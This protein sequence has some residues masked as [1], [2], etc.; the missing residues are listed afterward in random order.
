MRFRILLLLPLCM[1]CSRPET[2]P[3]SRVSS[4]P[5]SELQALQAQGITISA[6]VSVSVS[7]DKKFPLVLDPATNN[8]KGDVSVPTG[9]K[10][11]LTVTYTADDPTAGQTLQIA[12]YIRRNLI[13]TESTT[14]VSYEG[15]QQNWETTFDL[16]P[17]QVNDLNSDG[18]AY[19]NFIEIGYGSNPLA[20]TSLPLGAGINATHPDPLFG[21]TDVSLPLP[22][23]DLTSALKGDQEIKI[24]AVT[25]FHIQKIDIV[26]PT[27]GIDI[28]STN[29]EIRQ[30]KSL[31]LR[32]HTARFG[33]S[34]RMDIVIRTTDEF[35]IIRD[36]PL[37]FAIFNSTDALPPLRLQ[38]GL[39]EGQVV[40]DTTNFVWEI[41]DPSG[42]DP[43]SIDFH[44]T[45]PEVRVDE[46]IR[47]MDEDTTTTRFRG[48]A[49]LSTIRYPNGTYTATFA[50]R[51]SV[52][53]AYAET[54]HFQVLNTTTVGFCGNQI[55]E[56]GEECDDGNTLN[57]DSCTN[58]CRIG[59]CG[60]GIL[61]AGE[62]CDDGNT[63]DNDACTN[64][65]QPA[66]CGDGT[67]A[68]TEEC[69]DGNLISNDGC[70]STCRLEPAI[71][72]IAT[73][74]DG[75][76][77]H[78]IAN[79]QATAINRSGISLSRFG[80][81]LP[82]G[83]V[84]T[85]ASTQNFQSV[86]DTRQMPEDQPF[87]LQFEAEDTL[88]HTTVLNRTVI[89]NN[90]PNMNSFTPEQ[91]L[92]QSGSAGRLVW[93][94]TNFTS[95][96]IDNGVGA[97]S[98]NSVSVS[99][100]RT[101][102]YT[103]TATRDNH[104]NNSPP[105]I[106]TNTTLARLRV[107]FPPE[108]AC[109]TPC[110]TSVSPDNATFQWTI[111]NDARDD[112]GCLGANSYDFRIEKPD[113]TLVLART[114]LTTNSFNASQ[115]T[116]TEK[117]LSRADYLWR[118]TARDNCGGSRT[119]SYFNFTTG[120]NG[121]V[122]WWRFNEASGTTALDSNGSS[123]NAHPGTLL[124]FPSS[125]RVS[126]VRG[127]ALTFDGVNDSVEVPT[128][129]ILNFGTN[130][131]TLSLWVNR[132]V[133][134]AVY[135]SK[136]DVS[137]GWALSIASS[138]YFG[139]SIPQCGTFLSAR[140][141]RGG[142]VH[143]GV[144]RKGEKFFLYLDGRLVSAGTCFDANLTTTA[145]LRMGCASGTCEGEGRDSFRGLLDEVALYNRAMGVDEMR[146]ECRRNDLTGIP[147]PDTKEPIILSP[148]PGEILPPTMAYWSWRGERGED[149][150]EIYPDLTYRL[151]LDRD[152]HNDGIYD[153]IDQV[154]PSASMLQDSNGDWHYVEDR[155]TVIAQNRNY[156]LHITPIENSSV[157]TS[158]ESTRSFST[159]NSLL[160]WWRFENNLSDESGR[161]HSG[162]SPGGRS[163]GFVALGDLCGSMG[164]T[165]LLDRSACFN[166]TS[167][168]VEVTD[169]EIA[170]SDFDLTRALSIT[171]WVNPSTVNNGEDVLITKSGATYTTGY[172]LV[173]NVQPTPSN[174]VSYFYS[175][176]AGPGASACGVNGTI[177]PSEW[178]FVG[179]SRYPGGTG[180]SGYAASCFLD[181]SSNTINSRTL[182]T[183]SDRVKLGIG[184]YL[185][186]PNYFSGLMDE[187]MIYNRR[188]TP[189]NMCNSYLAF[190]H[191]AGL[192]CHDDCVPDH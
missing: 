4:M 140:Y 156:R 179:G 178:H 173:L 45:R 29:D 130:D 124:R 47:V 73:P 67:K 144:T 18:D 55:V 114:N 86:W 79:I 1:A 42:I 82:A 174:S 142:W 76:S 7:P 167:S 153:V 13:A 27:Y 16:S 164:V 190:C 65:C 150:R 12:R 75:V 157:L 170:G 83:L 78:D 53:N 39:Q 85:D 143:V 31:R 74:A 119:S 184:E 148:T 96:S 93:D 123:G 32:V 56:S 38:L 58:N 171:A 132:D 60:D 106:F 154:I 48:N 46:S 24:Q 127:G 36:T 104:L 158:Y 9:S 105:N 68:T 23:A 57:T 99:P 172:G 135:L 89:V 151:S 92:I 91:P 98:S 111:T 37:A 126:G 169:S 112:S 72:T 62:Q 188:L 81:I 30:A 66:R 131:F 176:Y 70:S 129:T 54:L 97:V 149:G 88:N 110:N 165:E 185:G 138:N 11:D 161:S 50:A 69:D 80:A 100:S 77:V 118:V 5:P 19:N 159:D 139:F 152:N 146:R 145:S 51:D 186:V 49:I 63:I 116:G 84:D 2:H 3:G 120:D 87:T 10:F 41:D 52:G 160:G 133:G 43:T 22:G 34:G 181:A 107:N 109:S 147:C 44:V 191:E 113:H 134:N 180:S 101:T 14:S 71:I 25:P 20:A 28:L 162:R 64:T 136:E 21:Q 35:G 103:L 33:P 108:V 182:D 8:F 192:V 187:V 128:D 61:S 189:F 137:N 183:N 117:L 90:V 163:P 6:Y 175:G 17:G 122:G 115:L 59:R 125:P 15:D 141:P 40:R 155:S 168:Y 94:V 26:S 102:T 95:L 121:L 177:R 166:G